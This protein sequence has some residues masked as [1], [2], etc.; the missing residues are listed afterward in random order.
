[1]KTFLF[2]LALLPA[3]AIGVGLKVGFYNKSCLSVET[4]Q[5]FLHRKE[6]ADQ[7]RVF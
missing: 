4:C 7:D 1:M 2:I 6:Y 5:C 3:S